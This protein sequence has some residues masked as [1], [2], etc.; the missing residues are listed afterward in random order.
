MYKDLVEKVKSA[1]EGR[2]L[3]KLFKDED[4]RRS[5]EVE[6]LDETD[7]NVEVGCRETRKDYGGSK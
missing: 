6:S 2:E 3:V 7:R 5:E 4:R 1:N